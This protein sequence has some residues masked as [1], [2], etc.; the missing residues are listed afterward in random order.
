MSRVTLAGFE[1]AR[2]YTPADR[3]T[4]DLIVIHDMEHPETPGTAHN[5]TSWFAGPTA[6]QASAH[7]C[8]DDAEVWGSV[9]DH[10]VAWHAPGANRNG[11]GIEHAGYANQTPAGW[12]DPYSRSMLNLSARL[13][14]D[15]VERWRI[16]VGYV[17]PAEL[18]AGHRGITTHA[19]VSTAFHRSTHTDPGPNFPMGAYLN[20]IRA[21]LAGSTSETPVV[22]VN[23][24]AVAILTHPAW[25]AGAYVEVCSDGG[26]FGFGGAPFYGSDAGHPLNSPIVGGAATPTGGGYWL[27]AADGGVFAHGDA[28]FHG[29][30]G[31]QPLNRPITS[32]APS[33][34]GHGYLLV[35]GDGGTFA[36]GDATYHGRVEY[37]G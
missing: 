7:Y 23:A 18:V 5:V 2:H 6:P 31:G 30:A 3:K 12:D 21:A 13:A 9:R 32:F 37:A 24:P 36:Y 20:S 22:K 33:P 28:E 19:A 16:P 35:G 25:P 15:L 29:S 4:I 11:I 26:V 1:Q 14:A 17:G 8:V 34:S 10:D 27:V